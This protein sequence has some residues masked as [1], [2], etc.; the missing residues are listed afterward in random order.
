MTLM[1]LAGCCGA[2][3]A[4]TGQHGWLVTAHRVDQEVDYEMIAWADHE[5]IQTASPSPLKVL[6]IDQEND[7]CSIQPKSTVKPLA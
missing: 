1:I 3:A 7:K 4:N 6:H 2:P 5:R